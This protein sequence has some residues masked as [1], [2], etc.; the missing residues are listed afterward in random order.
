MALLLV[1]DCLSLLSDC[2]YLI[3]EAHPQNLVKLGDLTCPSYVNIVGL[4][5]YSYINGHEMFMAHY[6]S[7]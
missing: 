1:S 6:L 5:H 7:G 2:V 4:S 3:V